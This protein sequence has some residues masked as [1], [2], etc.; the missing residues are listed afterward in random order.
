MFYP[1][2]NLYRWYSFT[3]INSSMRLY[4]FDFEDLTKLSVNLSKDLKH[5]FIAV[6]RKVKSQTTM[7]EINHEATIRMITAAFTDANVPIDSTT[8]VAI[9]FRVSP[10]NQFQIGLPSQES[11]WSVIKCKQSIF[12]CYIVL[13]N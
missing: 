12:D 10:V 4:T 9:Q 7:N 8:H 5:S 13:V 3:M 1:T 2:E 11:D 6:K